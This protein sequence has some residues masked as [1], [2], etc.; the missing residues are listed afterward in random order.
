MERPKL[1]LIEDVLRFLDGINGPDET[2][3]DV[4]GRHRV[5]NRKESESTLRRFKKN[6]DRVMDRNQRYESGNIPAGRNQ[7]ANTTNRWQ[8][9]AKRVLT[10]CSAGLLRSP[11]AANVLHRE[12]TYNTRACG[13]CLDFALIPMSETLIYWAD[14]IVFVRN[15]NYWEAMEVF[16]KK[17]EGKEIIVL[18]VPDEHAWNDIE[19]QEAIKREYLE[20]KPFKHVSK[21]ENKTS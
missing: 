10:V 17:M 3:E 9:N 1:S 8:T 2:V 7:L 21:N 13:S 4:L 16:D 18:D 12:F 5:G 15:T 6:Y 11:T 19:L 14:Q 20:A